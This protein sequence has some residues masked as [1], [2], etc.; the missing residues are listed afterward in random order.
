MVVS[1]QSVSPIFFRASF[2]GTGA[3]T[4]SQILAT[5]MGKWT[6]DTLTKILKKL[7]P[8]QHVYP[9]V[10]IVGGI[11]KTA[12]SVGSGG[13]AHFKQSYVSWRCNVSYGSTFCITGPLCRKFNNLLLKHCWHY[14]CLIVYVSLEFHVC[15]K[16]IQTG[17]LLCQWASEVVVRCTPSRCTRYVKGAGYNL[18]VN[19][20]HVTNLQELG[21][22][23]DVS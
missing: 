18:S 7:Q 6:I 23:C 8:K 20:V 3:F 21:F 12:T 22:V 19:H 4:W 9:M 14:S 11:D 5:N 16:G 15:N 10:Y 17:P 2:T 13:G 1:S